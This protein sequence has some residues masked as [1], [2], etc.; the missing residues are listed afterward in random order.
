M[1]TSSLVNRNP[2]CGPLVGVQQGDMA[3][4]LGIPF[5]RPLSGA[6]RFL[7]P[8]PPDQWTDPRTAFAYGP[9]APQPDQEKTLI[10]E[11]QEAG[12]AYLNLNV[13]APRHMPEKPLPVM[14]Y[15]HGGGYWA[16]C[17][18]SPWFEGETFVRDDVIVV[19]PSYRLGVEGF[20]PIKDAPN[21]RA[22]LDWLM[23]LEWVQTNIAEFGGDPSR[24]T[25]AGQSAGAGAVATLL[26]TPRA[27]GLFH[28]AI[29][30]SGS[31]GFRGSMGRAKAF[32]D[33]FS[34]ATGRDVT[35]ADLATLTRKDLIAAYSKAV[36][37]PV[38]EGP[39]GAFLHGIRHGLALQPIPE[40]ATLPKPTEE[41]FASGAGA[42]IPVLLT[43][44]RDEF[45]FEFE[46]LG[47]AVTDEYLS[48]V[49]NNFEV[50]EAALRQCYPGFE[51]ARLLGQM[52]SDV[53]MRAPMIDMA[54]LRLRSGAVET[55]TAEFRQ[56][57]PVSFAAP[58]RAAHCLDMPY[59]F[60]KTDLASA[61]DVCGPDAPKDLEASMHRSIV[62]FVHGRSPG[63]QDW[64][65]SGH[66]R[67]WGGDL[68]GSET[69]MRS[70]LHYVFG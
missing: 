65:R 30:F 21:N 16:G 5:A 55:W 20:M 28:R 41:A 46:P 18:R 9:T 12:D 31:I 8:E 35:V 24:I 54:R 27:E 19:S 50:D 23:A 22:I 70:D 36:V 64:A 11:P 49:L 47:D 33:R 39:G 34:A 6:N 14:I 59:Y 61:Q 58:L 42:D 43:T 10:P 69:D 62:D 38:A 29:L 52:A 7:A 26:A 68:D 2:P 53:L 13:F 3:K 17:N 45:V 56:A 66:T 4:F 1:D 57:S 60:E 44:T 25:L 15:I 40:T 48:R 32:A 51:N 63:W 37:D 67:I